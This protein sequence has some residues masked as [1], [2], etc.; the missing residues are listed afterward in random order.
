M[1]YESLLFAASFQITQFHLAKSGGAPFFVMKRWS[2]SIRAVFIQELLKFLRGIYT[3]LHTN[4]ALKNK[5]TDL[6]SLPSVC[7]TRGGLQKE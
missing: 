3:A 6:F 4:P 7:R 5:V 1:R 2:W